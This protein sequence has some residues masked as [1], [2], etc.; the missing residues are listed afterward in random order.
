MPRTAAASLGA[1]EE[2]AD[3]SSN[4]CTSPPAV[5]TACDDVVILQETADER[6]ARMGCSH[7]RS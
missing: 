4:Y 1:K 5:E 6:H 7:Y 2:L 3:P